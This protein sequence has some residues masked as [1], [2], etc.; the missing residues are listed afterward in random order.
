MIPHGLAIQVG[1]KGEVPE[2]KSFPYNIGNYECECGTK[3]NIFA[4]QVHYADGKQFSKYIEKL[5]KKDHDRKGKHPD[6]IKLPMQAEF[7]T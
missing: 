1:Y 3:Y 2:A 4:D 5:L 7:T 6:V